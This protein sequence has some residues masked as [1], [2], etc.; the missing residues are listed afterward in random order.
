LPATLGSNGARGHRGHPDL[1]ATY[2]ATFQHP[3]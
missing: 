1:L 2:L 3:E